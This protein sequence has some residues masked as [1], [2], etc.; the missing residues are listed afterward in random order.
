MSFLD[1]KPFIVS[2]EDYITAKDEVAVW[3]GCPSGGW[4][5]CAMCG[6]RFVEG[7]G[8]RWLYMND[9]VGYSGNP[10]ICSACDGDDVLDRWKAKIDEA[11]SDKWWWFFRKV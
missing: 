3:S 11:R 10:L 8:A 2:A 5:R 4:F 1:G 6:H 7:D 9:I